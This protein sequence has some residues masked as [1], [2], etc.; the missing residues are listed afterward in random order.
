MDTLTYPLRVT[1]QY[2]A[3][4]ARLLHILADLEAEIGGTCRRTLYMTAESLGHPGAWDKALKVRVSEV[5]LDKALDDV[6]DKVGRSDTGLVL[7]WGDSRALGVAPPF[8]LEHQALYD[9][10][11][12]SGLA[13]LFSKDLVVGI[14]L[15]RLSHYAVGVL[16]GDR[17]VASK[18]GSRYV[19]SRHRAGG[20]SQRRFERSRE[21]LV[22]E[23]FDATCRVA[24]DVFAPFQGTIEYLL[25][26]GERHTLQAF[27]RRCSYLERAAR[28]TLARRLD[29]KRPGR[30]ALERM[31]EEV[32]KSR[33]FVLER[34]DEQISTSVK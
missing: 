27:A 7:F 9:G 12:T 18:S 3:S 25:M 20:S 13:D 21:R 31:P 24:R 23:L 16:Q 34:D 1:R 4:K 6:I 2:W 17:L 22:R 30:A 26:G 19:K 28:G 11:L 5:G 33:V 32:W 8:P 15:L 10:A 29:V 14:V